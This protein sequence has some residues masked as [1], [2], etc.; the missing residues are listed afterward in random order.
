MQAYVDV[1][2]ET[3]KNLGDRDLLILAAL[4]KKKIGRYYTME[5]QI[6]LSDES[7]VSAELRKRV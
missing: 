3:L 1:E 7:I 5:S 4:V 6:L 2:G